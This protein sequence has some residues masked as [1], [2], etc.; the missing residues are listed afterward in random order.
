MHLALFLFP[1][2]V[3]S[4]GLKTFASV[5]AFAAVASSPGMFISGMVSVVGDSAID[6]VV[7]DAI[8]STDQLTSF[9]HHLCFKLPSLCTSFLN[10]LPASPVSPG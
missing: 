9:H 1:G 2:V 8:L 7:G 5:L 6:V 4:K 3:R 10:F